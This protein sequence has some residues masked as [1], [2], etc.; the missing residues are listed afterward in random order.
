MTELTRAEFFKGAGEFSAS[1]YASLMRDCEKI[2]GLSRKRFSQ[3]AEEIP[4]PDF[5]NRNKRP[6][7]DGPGG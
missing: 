5:L 4:G 2:P 6:R 1:F 7:V 3:C